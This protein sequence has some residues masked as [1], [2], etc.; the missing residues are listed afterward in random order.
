[1]TDEKKIAIVPGGT[2]ECVLPGHEALPE[3]ARP[4]FLL[5]FLSWKDQAEANRLGR[6]MGEA[7]DE[8]VDE[9]MEK[10]FTLCLAGWRNMREG[11]NPD[12]A[13][14]PFDVAALREL[15]TES[16]AT[17]LAARCIRAGWLSEEQLKNSASPSSSAQ[18]NSAPGAGAATGAPKA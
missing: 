4:V 2:A 16:Q 9:L 6:A 13:A 3:A 10:I 1:M 12:A 7:E 18:E 8:K 17:H 11:F 15:L 5:R 14:V